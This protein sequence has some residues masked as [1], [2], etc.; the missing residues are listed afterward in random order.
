MVQ[1]EPLKTS[2][3]SFRKALTREPSG[4]DGR[5]AMKLQHRQRQ[6]FVLSLVI[7]VMVVA[8]CT[9]IQYRSM[10]DEQQNL[11][12]CAQA[13]RT[14]EGEGGV[15]RRVAASVLSAI[16]S[17]KDMA[18]VRVAMTAL[19]VTGV[20]VLPKLTAWCAAGEDVSTR[21]CRGMVLSLVFALWAFC[22]CGVTQSPSDYALGAARQRLATPASS[23]HGFP[24]PPGL[25]LAEGEAD[26]A[27]L[28]LTAD[29]EPS[30]ALLATV[31]IASVGLLSVQLCA[32]MSAY[33]RWGDR[34]SGQSVLED[35]WSAS[36]EPS[37]TQR[38]GGKTGEL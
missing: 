4:S 35:T 16:Q 2:D 9:G 19:L 8:L 29:T 36:A 7:M 6:V 11:D 17:R 10:Q 5:K 28:E 24:S 34:S 26:W 14:L 18:W 27:L 13:L 23:G 32:A 20:L 1:D 3:E 38:N 33:G 25:V 21:L 31:F 30:S 15:S 22:V 37:E 12:R